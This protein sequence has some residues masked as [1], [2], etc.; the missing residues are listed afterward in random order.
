VEPVI[1]PEASNRIPDGNIP[2]TTRQL[3]GGTPPFADRVVLYPTPISAPGRDG[4]ETATGELDEVLV[5]IMDAE[6][7]ISRPVLAFGLSA[8]TTTVV[9]DLTFGAV[10]SPVLEI[11]PALADQV[12]AV[13]A[14]PLNVAVNCTCCEEPIVMLVGE[15][16]RVLEVV[17]VTEASCGAAL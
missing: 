11:V 13:L 10:K 2:L 4:V 9:F 5:T 17:G 3:Y 14:V 7:R 16:E 6:A 12:T 8:V 1:D 15:S